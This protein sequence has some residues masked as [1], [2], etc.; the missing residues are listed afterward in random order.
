MRILETL[1]LSL[2]LCVGVA[3]QTLTTFAVNPEASTLA[4]GINDNGDVVGYY[5]CSSLRSADATRKSEKFAASCAAVRLEKSSIL[6][7]TLARKRSI[8]PMSTLG[9]STGIPRSIRFP[10]GSW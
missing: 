4:T 3:A 1:L 9:S 6:V 5:G 8:I 7:L 10:A 2:S